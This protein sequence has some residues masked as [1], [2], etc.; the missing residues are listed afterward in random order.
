MNI[1]QARETALRMAEDGLPESDIDL[2]LKDQGFS[3]AQLRMSNQLNKAIEELVQQNELRLVGAGRGL[4]EAWEGVKSV[5]SDKG[6]KE[7]EEE[8]RVYEKA[9]SQES[10]VNQ[11]AM[12]QSEIVAN[13]APFAAIPAGGASAS[14]PTRL[15]LGMIGGGLAA[16]LGYVPPGEDEARRRV[17]NVA[18]GV[19]MGGATTAALEPVRVAAGRAT[20]PELGARD[21]EITGLAEKHNIPLSFG[22]VRGG[23]A[24]QGE[25]VLQEIPVVG[26]GRFRRSQQAF[27][28]S[29]AKT[30]I[31]KFPAAQQ[32]QSGVDAFG[33]PIFSG[34]QMDAQKAIKT[35]LSALKRKE[36]VLYKKVADIADPYGAMKMDNT[37]KT[38]DELIAEEAKK[39][40]P[41]PE[42][43]KIMQN[44]KDA[45][46][47]ATEGR[48]TNFSNVH[49]YRQ[50]I[51]DDIDSFYTG[52]NTLLPKSDVRAYQRIKNAID[53][54]MK[55]FTK[56]IGNDAY[57]S[58]KYADGFHRSRVAPYREESL[59]RTLAD[60]SD[61]VAVYDAFLSGLKTN[62]NT[63]YTAM[64]KK[65]QSA[66]RA[67]LLDDTFK[68]SFD[69]RLGFDPSKF[70]KI[71]KD[72]QREIG[73]V[74]KGTDLDEINGFVKLMQHLDNTGEF[75]RRPQVQ[76]RIQSMGIAG[77]AG[78]IGYFSPLWTAAS[79]SA[80]YSLSKLLSSKEGRDFL[81]SSNKAKPGP[82]MQKIIDYYAPRLSGLISGKEE[83]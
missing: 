5:F 26:M 54:D 18:A 65:G 64:G 79:G 63:V 76:S 38:I 82:S 57:D 23:A 53:E 39:V 58:W 67:G 41:N 37:I 66:L 56:S 16:G 32:G 31:G 77:A 48:R 1:D 29:A 19:A 71:L 13:T 9:K 35:R 69:E 24:G 73:V 68:Q 8:K 4:V 14:F 52:K 47:K 45:L 59:L 33:K 44:E 30:E 10:P 80:V 40:K 34:W 49:E 74:F 22:D 43:V 78:V 46:M 21:K 51:N 81:L 20:N 55:S 3:A 2:W 25:S 17:G 62:P 11:M 72:R 15:G 50:G 75:V 70:A 27:S 7:Y 6:A 61:P 60:E 83:E 36:S 28:E 12:S 42:F